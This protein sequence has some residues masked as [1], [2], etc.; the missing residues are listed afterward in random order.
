MPGRRPWQASSGSPEFD[1][2]KEIPLPSLNLDGI[3]PADGAA[4]HAADTIHAAEVTDG[5]A[6]RPAWVVDGG[7]SSSVN[8]SSA[9]PER[10]L[11]C[12]GKPV[13]PET[14]AAFSRSGNLPTRSTVLPRTDENGRAVVDTAAPSVLAAAESMDSSVRRPQHP[15]ALYPQNTVTEDTTRFSAFSFSPPS[16]PPELTAPADGFGRGEETGHELTDPLPPPYS[17][18]PTQR[19]T[20]ANE[21]GAPEF[22]GL[23][24]HELTTVEAI[25]PQESDSY[26]GSRLSA[27]GCRSDISVAAL[28]PGGGTSDEAGGCEE[29]WT[30][31]AR[32]K[33]ICGGRCL[34][35]QAVA[36]VIIVILVIALIGG[37]VTGTRAHKKL[38]QLE[39]AQHNITPTPSTVYATTTTTYDASPLA[40]PPPNLPPL[41]AGTFLLS[42][43]KQQ[44]F[45]S[46]CLA[47]PAQA[48][49]WSCDLS[50]TDTPQLQIEITAAQDGSPDLIRLSIPESH[51][52][53]VRHGTQPPLVRG[54]QN[55]ALVVD[56]LSLDAGPAYVF[57]AS[58]TK[59]VI[60]DETKLTLPSPGGGGGNA[61][62]RPP[63]KR[64]LA[65]SLAAALEHENDAG[66]APDEMRRRGGKLHKKAALRPGDRPWYCYWN[67]TV[68]EGFIYVTKNAA[69]TTGP[70]SLS[71]GIAGATATS[72]A[73][74]SALLDLHPPTFPAYPKLV[75]LMERR[76]PIVDGV[77]SAPPRRAYCQ[78]MQVLDDMSLGPVTQPGS[79]ELAILYLSETSSGPSKQKRADLDL[80]LEGRAYK[81]M[82]DL[83][84]RALTPNRCFCAWTSP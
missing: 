31:K 75:K 38:A 25:T 24:G 54:P 35:W 9:S 20:V 36:A 10:R 18:Y 77:G 14:I 19:P 6:P 62:G 33:R 69:N 1:M 41:P 43:H 81:S 61:G 29:K 71:T 8:Y 28:N 11:S 34:V 51:S 82:S 2:D 44:A 79:N 32:K 17:R 65:E 72:T 7:Q 47:D 64:D 52:A 83:T 26:A 59:L 58:Y 37:L 15:Y 40:T 27:P 13:L 57:Q 74:P 67:G 21:P 60:L 78:Q 4:V 3:A 30:T 23:A 49:A 73:V 48:E 50:L 76:D 53:P 68:L 22:V 39:D 63:T 84:K 80:D 45:E 12:K 46:E 70:T 42:L 66:P 56:R 16:F 55:L 5:F